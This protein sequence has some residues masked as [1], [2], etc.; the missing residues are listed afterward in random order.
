MRKFATIKHE[1]HGKLKAVIKTR[2]G[3]QSINQMDYQVGSRKNLYGHFTLKQCELNG[4]SRE[5]E[6]KTLYK[7]IDIKEK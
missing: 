1:S 6:K 2:S 3:N 4:Y 7:I 5:Y